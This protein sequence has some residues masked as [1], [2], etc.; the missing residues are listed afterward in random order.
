MLNIP[1]EEDIESMGQTISPPPPHTG[2]K[3]GKGNLFPAARQTPIYKIN[4]TA[5]KW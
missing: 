4:F 2:A 3:I 1:A 5:A